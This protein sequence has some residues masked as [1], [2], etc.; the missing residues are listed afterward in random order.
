[1]SVAPLLCL[2]GCDNFQP[3]IAACVRQQAWPDV[4]SAS[5]PARCG[6]PPMDWEALRAV[7]PPQC[8]EVLVMGSACIRKLGP[9]PPDFPPVQLAVQEQCFHLVCGKTAVDQALA[10]GGYLMSPAWLRHWQAHLEQLGFSAATAAEFFQGF[11]KQLVLFDTGIDSAT[12]QQAQDIAQASGLPVQR[13]AV[14]FDHLQLVLGNAVLDWRLAQ[15]QATLE[16]T[17]KAH[18]AELADHVCALD[19]LGRLTEQREEAEVI[20][21]IEDL[22]RMLFAPDT[23]VYLDHGSAGKTPTD[24]AAQTL[25]GMALQ[26]ERPY[27]W[28]PSGQGFALLLTHGGQE[29]GR[30]LVDGLAFAQYRERYL[31]MALAMASVCALAIDSAR[32]RKRL[33]QA[34]KMASLGVMVAGIA[35][36]INTPLGVGVLAISTMQHQTAKL[37]QGFAER[38]MTQSDLHGYLTE[39]S[40]QTALI[41]SNLERIGQLIDAFRQIAVNGLPQEKVPLALRRCILEVVASLGARFDRTKYSIAIDCDDALEVLS[42]PGDWVSVFTNL[43]GN[44]LQHGFKGLD[45]GAI[46][47]EV[48]QSENRLLITYRD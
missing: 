6:R 7:L 46:Q 32:T 42:C 3:E 23:L 11:A 13:Q 31:N 44:S 19:L 35:H 24:S 45:R 27:A 5:F 40:A 36:E 2:L 17:Q 4:V 30:L 26:P 20:L 25:R 38:R 43:I 1:T 39:S 18:G 14:G 47:I 10:E 48:R 15:A 9:A 8:T 34:E 41:R 37:S 16:R 28:T 33:V 22:F 21:A 29:A 12:A